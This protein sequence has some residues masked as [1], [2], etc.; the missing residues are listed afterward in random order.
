VGCDSR[1]SIAWKVTQVNKYLCDKYNTVLSR[2]F[3]RSS[4]FGAS[5]VRRESRVDEDRV[6]ST[7]VAGRGNLI[8]EVFIAYSIA[9]G[10]LSG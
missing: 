7:A 5:P 6:Q 3:R 4:D 2:R 9:C 8:H 1:K 10:R